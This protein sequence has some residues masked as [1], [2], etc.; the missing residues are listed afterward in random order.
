MIRNVLIPDPTFPFLGRPSGRREA[1][2]RFRSARVFLLEW[3]LIL[4]GFLGVLT[5]FAPRANAAPRG[6]SSLEEQAVQAVLGLRNID[7]HWSP[8]ST[9]PVGSSPIGTGSPSTKGV[10]TY[11][12]GDLPPFLVTTVRQAFSRATVKIRA[13]R[14]RESGAEVEATAQLNLTGMTGFRRESFVLDFELFGSRDRSGWTLVSVE[15]P[16]QESEAESL[17]LQLADS[18]LPGTL[19]RSWAAAEATAEGLLRQRDQEQSPLTEKEVLASLGPVDAQHMLKI[20][21]EDPDPTRGLVA[22][23]FLSRKGK[24]PFGLFV[25]QDVATSPPK[26]SPRLLAHALV[27]AELG[28]R[29]LLPRLGDLLE[30]ERPDQ[31]VLAVLALSLLTYRRLGTLEEVLGPRAPSKTEPPSDLERH[32]REWSL[33]LEGWQDRSPDEWYRLAVSEQIGH[34]RESM[35]QPDSFAQQLRH[36]EVLIPRRSRNDPKYRATGNRERTVRRWE[37]WFESASNSLRRPP[38]G[39]LLDRLTLALRK[40][41]TA[42]ELDSAGK[43]SPGRTG[44]K[45]GGPGAR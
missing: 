26:T 25:L 30:S 1:R 24:E 31:Q 35:F 5:E 20:V 38:S 39:A 9:D 36:L 18:S 45:S 44:M 6:R 3:F 27:V 21:L 29:T 11:C 42:D 13:L 23:S 37:Q 15:L 4:G 14:L 32:R 41:P 33:W 12:L 17:L 7:A 28:G 19:L 2:A 34:L 43:R 22:A 8:P 10:L 40:A 16:R